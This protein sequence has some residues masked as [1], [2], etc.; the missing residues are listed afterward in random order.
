MMGLPAL[1]LPKIAGMR[2]KAEIDR[3]IGN[4]LNGEPA[5]F[6]PGMRFGD[7]IAQVLVQ[8]DDRA[9]AKHCEFVAVIFHQTANDRL[10]CEK[11]AIDL[12]FARV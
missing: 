10:E 11:I 3:L 6:K 4:L 5:V 2:E 9:I 8:A 12:G 7:R 1:E